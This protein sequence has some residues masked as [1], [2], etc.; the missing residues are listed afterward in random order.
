[1]DKTQRENWKFELLGELLLAMGSSPQLRENLIFK[2]ALILNH[3]LGSHRKSLDIDS[4]LDREFT[5]HH[6]N[7]E[8][9]RKFLEEHVELAISR[10][11]EK[12]NPVRYELKNLRIVSSPKDLH[13]R[14][15]DGFLI[16]VTLIDH[17]NPGVRGLPSLTIDVAAPESLSEH[18]VSDLVLQGVKI[19][20]YTLERIAGEKAR[21]FLST[22]PTYRSK[23][24]KPGESVRVKDL[25]DLTKILRLKPL[26]EKQFWTIA[27]N[28]FSLA[29]QSRGIDCVGQA[30]F[31]EN[32]GETKNFYEK[33]P[34]IPTD[35]P[36]NDVD[37]AIR[38]ISSY[39]EEIGII[40]LF[41]EL[42]SRQ[43]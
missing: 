11:F 5:T 23:V 2:G 6:P 1:M 17:S 13:P 18:S 25:Y 31:L 14:G 43:V 7:Q 16:T 20:A 39:W 34:T 27:G 12:K 9:Q 24:K 37:V 22:L 10:H 40:P 28:E 36:F 33:D 19:R 41:F 21:A 15:W 38:S 32:W 4:N 35:I 26:D 29:C 30:S 3:H 42:P 8:A